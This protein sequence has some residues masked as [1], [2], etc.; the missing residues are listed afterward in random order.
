MVKGRGHETACLA[1]VGSE[2]VC[3]QGVSSSHKA[4]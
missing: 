2:T 3:A 4:Q 1:R